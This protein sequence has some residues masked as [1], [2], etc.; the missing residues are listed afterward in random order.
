M[1][2]EAEPCVFTRVAMEAHAANPLSHPNMGLIK[3]YGIYRRGALRSLHTFGLEPSSRS[4]ECNSLRAK[5]SR[6]SSLTIEPRFR[7]LY[8]L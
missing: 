1:L 4:Q 8:D 3:Q 7:D 5:A 2:C 6:D